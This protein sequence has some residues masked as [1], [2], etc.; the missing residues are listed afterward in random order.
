MERV[1]SLEQRARE[2]PAGLHCD[3]VT[4]H[5][6][7]DVLGWPAEAPYDAIIVAAAAPSVPMELIEQLTPG[8]RM[9]I[10]VGTPFEQVLVLV[11]RTPD[12][13]RAN[14]LGECRFVP[15]IGPGAWDAEAAD[16]PLEKV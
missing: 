13:L 12:G 16:G 14:P 6:A 8:G 3:N 9:V 4:V 11:M 2:V 1:A 7:G 15:L 5:L 10:P